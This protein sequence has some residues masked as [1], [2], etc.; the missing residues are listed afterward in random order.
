MQEYTPTDQWIHLACQPLAKL[1]RTFVDSEEDDSHTNLY[2][3]PVGHRIYGRWIHTSGNNVIGA[4]NLENWSFEILAE[5]FKLLSDFRLEGVVPTALEADIS[6]ELDD[7]GLEADGFS[8]PLHFEITDYPFRA[9]PFPGLEDLN[10][11]LWMQIRSLGNNACVLFLG[12]LQ[13]QAEVRIWPHHFDTGVYH[14][15]SDDLGIGFGLA[16]EDDM[17]G[18]P[19]LYMA[20]YGLP[21]EAFTDPTPLGSGK[22]VI[23]DSWK[24]AVLAVDERPSE[25]DVK[26]FISDGVAHFLQ[27]A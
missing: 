10:P 15:K 18:A 19:Y 11:Q 1:N 12:H 6:S 4:V 5:D 16:M 27:F 24:G 3:D 21:D 17:V 9:D 20:G 2:F 7:I 13:A 22:W 14:Q 25:E 8:D 26:H 23:K